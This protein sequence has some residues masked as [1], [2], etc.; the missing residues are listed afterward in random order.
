[1]APLVSVVMSTYNRAGVVER[2]LEAA[3]DQPGPPFEIVVV[4]DGSTDATPKVLAAVDDARLRVVQQANAGMASAR[5]TG[6]AAAEGEWLIFLDDDDVPVRG[7]LLALTEP[8][9]DAEVGITCC[10]ARGVRPDGTEICPLPAIPLGPPFGDVVGAYRAGTFAVRTELFRR[11]GGYLDGLGTSEQFELFLRLL[12]EAE[13]AGQRVVSTDDCALDIE[14]RPVDDR[15]S[16]NPHVAYDAT[17]WVLSRHARTRGDQPVFEARFEGV[18]GTTAA[19]IGRWSDARRHFWRSA[20]LEP[21]MRVRWARLALSYVPPLARQVWDRH[22]SGHYDST[23]AGVPMQLRAGPAGPADR[24]GATPE[25][26]LHWRYRENEPPADSD[27][28]PV[29]PRVQRLAD[30]VTRQHPG[31]I[32]CLGTLERHADPVGLLQELARDAADSTRGVLVSTPD[33]LRSDPDRPLGPPSNPRHRR[34]WS[35]EQLRLLLRSTGLDVSRTWHRGDD[36][37][38]LAHPSQVLDSP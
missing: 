11:A 30:R 18:A 26:F 1:M 7:W 8:M 16:S 37:V 14:R 22:G 32:H 24:P 19:R 21:C 9:V 15:R 5:N 34:E 27:A 28:R 38:V 6:A 23:Q 3:L 4:D 20:R 10:G 29:D 33:R 35:R 2:T 36:M 12:V 31:T 13:D 17:T 25:L